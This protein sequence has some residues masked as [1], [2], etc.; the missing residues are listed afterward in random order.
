MV[1]TLKADIFHILESQHKRNISAA[2]KARL[3]TLKHMRPLFAAGV[4][5][6]RGTLMERL[7]LT[8]AYENNSLRLS[9]CLIWCLHI[10]PLPKRDALHTNWNANIKSL[11]F[12]KEPSEGYLVRKRICVMVVYFHWNIINT[13]HTK[14]LGCKQH[15][16][17]Y[18]YCT[19]K[20]W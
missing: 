9:C 2:I 4:S 8:P 6:P 11:L 18:R 16:I 19:I 7:L 3:Q 13:Q 12:P 10:D 20:V 14:T 17:N 5:G 1:C 15:Q